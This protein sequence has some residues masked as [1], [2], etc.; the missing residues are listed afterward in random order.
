MS[1]AKL[2]NFGKAAEFKN[3]LNDPLSY[4]M[5]TELDNGFMHG[6]HATNLNTRYG[7]QC[8][9]FMAQ[10]CAKNFDELCELRAQS[11]GDG[12]SIHIEDAELFGGCENGSQYSDLNAGQIFLRNTAQV[13]Y[14]HRI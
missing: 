6:S 1:Y 5:S 10:R 7:K 14:L 13:K 3:S 9:R 11:K 2:I 4:C 8:R 12:Y